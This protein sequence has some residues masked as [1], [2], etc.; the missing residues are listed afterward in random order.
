MK[1]TAILVIIVFFLAVSIGQ[2][3]LTFTDNTT[4]AAVGDGGAG[5]GIAFGDY[6]ND[7]F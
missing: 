7:G 4:A 6:N 1:N 3:Q 2:A 5:Q